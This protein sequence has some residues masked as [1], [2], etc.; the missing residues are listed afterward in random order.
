MDAELL[1]SRVEERRR[2]GDPDIGGQ[3]QIQPGADGCAVDRRDR[4]QRTVGDREEAVVDGAQAVLGGGAERG[5]V[6]ACAECLTR[7]G[8]D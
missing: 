2:A 6:G 8:H 5:Q 3:R 4:G 1:E 7:A